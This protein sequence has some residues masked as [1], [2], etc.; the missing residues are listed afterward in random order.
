[1]LDYALRGLRAD[2][3]TAFATI[4]T[5]AAHT[6]TGQ[7]FEITDLHE[8]VVDDQGRIVRWKV[9]FD[10]NGEIAAFTSDANERLITASWNGDR[11]TV[12][13]VLDFGA[14]VNHRDQDSGL[15]AL[16]IAAGRADAPLTDLLIARGADVFTW[17]AAPEP[18]HCTRRARAAASTWCGR[19]SRQALCPQLHR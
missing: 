1:V 7:E 19:W 13:E 12:S 15:T 4:Y 16:M 17:T 3:D 8:M 18:P 5:K 2:D 11:A 10:P 9:Y 6:R 14:N